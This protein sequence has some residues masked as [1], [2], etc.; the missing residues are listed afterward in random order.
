MRFLYV[1]EFYSVISILL[2][3][4]RMWVLLQNTEE[5]YEICSQ[6]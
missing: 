6:N 3:S 4:S 1:V 2:I 5:F